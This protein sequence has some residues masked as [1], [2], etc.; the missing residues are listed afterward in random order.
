MA[1]STDVKTIIKRRLNQEHLPSKNFD[2]NLDYYIKATCAEVAFLKSKYFKDL[3]KTSYGMTD[4][5]GKYTFNESVVPYQLYVGGEVKNPRGWRRVTPIDYNYF[6]RNESGTTYHSTYANSSFQYSL[7]PS[8]TGNPD[9]TNIKLLNSPVE[10][11]IKLLYYPTMPDVSDF[12]SYF[13]PLIIEK[14]LAFYAFD[15]KM[16]SPDKYFVSNEKRIKE[17]EKIVLSK[18]L[19]IEAKRPTASV[20]NRLTDSYMQTDF[21]DLHYWR[22]GTRF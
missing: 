14:T 18:A 15:H 10:T 5:E 9:E 3:I 11:S 21:H 19:P 12:P 7:V 2:D 22:I 6:V 13:L 4:N 17:L 20:S 16:Q 8:E 1:T